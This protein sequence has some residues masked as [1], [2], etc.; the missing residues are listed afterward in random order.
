MH[1]HPVYLNPQTHPHLHHHHGQQ[2]QY[3]PQQQV[4]QH[5]MHQHM[6]HHHAHHNTHHRMPPRQMPPQQIPPQQLHHRPRY[7]THIVPEQIPQEMQQENGE[8]YEDEF[9][10]QRVQSGHTR[11]DRRDEEL[12]NIQKYGTL[13]VV[14]SQQNQYH[15]YNLSDMRNAELLKSKKKNNI[16]TPQLNRPNELLDNQPRTNNMKQKN[17]RH[18][19]PQS[20]SSDPNYAP[21]SQNIML[22]RDTINNRMQNDFDKMLPNMRSINYEK[23]NSNNRQQ[24]GSQFAS[25]QDNL[26]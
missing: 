4:P 13:D 22:S 9:D 24:R 11:L 12:N 20:S 6:H 8:E 25:V 18:Q 19:A 7:M 10:Q 16:Y 3:V 1:R 21:Y 15:K 2:I 17:N 26:L 5:A 14:R 23:L